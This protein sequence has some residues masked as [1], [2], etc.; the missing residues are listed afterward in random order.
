M[1][2]DIPNRKFAWRSLRWNVAKLASKSYWTWQR[3]LFVPVRV[4]SHGTDKTAHIRLG[5]QTFILQQLFRLGYHRLRVVADG[6]TVSTCCVDTVLLASKQFLLA[7]TEPRDV[8]VEVKLVQR[9]T[10][11]R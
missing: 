7:N 3:K 10:Q 4:E 6:E 8:V 2:Q 5:Y 9:Q 1:C 11:P